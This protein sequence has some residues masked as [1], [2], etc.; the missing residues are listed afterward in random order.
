MATLGYDDRERKTADPG[1][2]FLGCY[3]KFP[4]GDRNLRN[5]V[6][7]YPADFVGRNNLA[8]VKFFALD[9]EGAKEEGRRAVEIYPGNAITRSNYALYAMYS[10]D[11]ET[12]IAESE[13]T[14]ELDPTW[15]AAWLPV[16][17]R[18]LYEANPDSARAAYRSMAGT[19]AR[20]ASTASLGLADAELYAGNYEAAEKILIDGI[21]A[22]EEIGNIYGRA[23]KY[24][25]LAE[26]MAGL[27][28]IDASLDAIA[29]GRE[30]MENDATL[31]PAALLLIAAG[32][33]DAAMDIASF[34]AEKLSPQSRAYSGLISG[35]AELR[36]GNSLQAIEALTA[37]V[38]KADLWLLRFYLGRAYF[39]AGY[40]VEA[41]DE[42][43]SAADR[44]GEATALF[45]DDL[46]TYRYV[47]ALP[48]W[49]ARAQQELGMTDAANNNFRAFLAT[50]PGGGPLADDARQRLQ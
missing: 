10:S 19:S 15:F 40:F 9:F 6:A 33:T 47:S 36:L 24:L 11:F 48:Y 25:A 22:D 34:L 41:L 38:D 45:L 18:A 23:V 17:M 1:H 39:E 29:A 30:L 31:V 42:F 13:T 28:K 14:R 4:E 43:N 37:A 35:L 49:Q 32:D 12:A 5:A 27:G 7:R 16:A 8:V 26:A 2:L 3:P 21:E 20:G 44:H 46:P 50:R